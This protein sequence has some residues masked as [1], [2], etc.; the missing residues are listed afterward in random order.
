MISNFF[1]QKSGGKDGGGEKTPFFPCH[2][3]LSAVTLKGPVAELTTQLLDS[4]VHGFKKFPL[5]PSNLCH[6][7]SIT[8]GGALA[9]AP[10]APHGVGASGR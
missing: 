4:R 1:L 7:F 9:Q 8:H 5:S 10:P 3:L 6:V 2:R